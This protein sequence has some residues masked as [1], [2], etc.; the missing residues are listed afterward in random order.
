V[1]PMP[2]EVQ[3]EELGNGIRA[4]TVRGEL[5]MN[6]APELEDRLDEVTGETPKV[7]LDLSECDFIDST[8]IAVIVRSW[9]RLDRDGEGPGSGRL[10][11]CCDNTQVMRLLTITG[12]ESS[13]SVHAERAAAL[14]ELGGTPAGT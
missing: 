1:I 10:V 14:D 12:V 11:L 8:G 3:A 7:V 13:I 4:V 5:D 9:Q 6:T 2:F